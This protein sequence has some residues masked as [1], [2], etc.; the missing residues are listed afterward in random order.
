[1]ADP[2]PGTVIPALLDVLENAVEWPSPGPQVTLGSNPNLENQVVMLGVVDGD[3]DWAQIGGRKRDEDYTVDLFVLVSVPGDSALEACTRAW[4]LFARISATLRDP[5][6]IATGH[7]AGV[8]WNEVKRPR[9]VPTIEAEGHGYV[10]ESAVRF[11]AR[12]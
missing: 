11:R 5:D 4:D 9:G 1:M 6:H 10:I 12:I 2:T 3:E 8:L 7:D